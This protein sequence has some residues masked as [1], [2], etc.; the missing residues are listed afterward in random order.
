ME[1]GGDDDGCAIAG[2]SASDAGSAVLNMFMIMFSLC[3]AL[4]LRSRSAGE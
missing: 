4:C 3:F 1:E 2:A